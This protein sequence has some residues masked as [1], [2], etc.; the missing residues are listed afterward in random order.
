MENRVSVENEESLREVEQKFLINIF[1]GKQEASTWINVFEKE[2]IR[3]K[4]FDG[5][6]RVEVLKLF[7]DGNVKEWYSANLMK[8]SLSD[9][10]TWKKSF[11]LIYGKKTWSSIR[12]AFNYKYLF[13]SLIDFV[14]K[15][16]RLLFD[17][18]NRIPEL[19]R[20]YQ[21]VYSLPLEIQNKLERDKI[22]TID[23]LVK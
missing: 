9:W 19:F 1:N 14:L 5:T 8:L 21:I 17:A 12:T 13:G 10:E 15:K 23:D 6:T 18:D 3:F 2:C 11:L 16:E 20:I 7:I 4:I 22:N